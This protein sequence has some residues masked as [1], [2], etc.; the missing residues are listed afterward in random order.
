MDPTMNILPMPWLFTY[1]TLVFWQV[2]TNNPI[3]PSSD[4]EGISPYNI[5]TISSRQVMKNINWW[6]IN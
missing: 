3:T 6:I 2:I 1:S 4:Q 5:N